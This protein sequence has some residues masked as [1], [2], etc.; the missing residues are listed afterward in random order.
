MK[1]NLQLEA[2][3]AKFQRCLDLVVYVG[4]RQGLRCVEE[5]RTWKAP[6]VGPRP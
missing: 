2:V 5:V 4:K 6:G 3:L 1:I